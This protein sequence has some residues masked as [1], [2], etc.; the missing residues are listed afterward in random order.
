VYFLASKFNHWFKRIH[1]LVFGGQLFLG[2]DFTTIYCS[3]SF[4][5]PFLSSFCLQTLTLNSTRESDQAVVVITIRVVGELGPTDPL[6]VQ[7]YNIILRKWMGTLNMEEINRIFYDPTRAIELPDYK[8]V[9]W[10]GVKTSLRQ[11]ENSL[12]LNVDITHKV[13]RTDSVLDNIRE[14]EA[15]ARGGNKRVCKMILQKIFLQ[16]T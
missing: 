6:R 1:K 10:P 8:L 9:L 4:G 3:F 13:L 12:L 14:I 16:K 2:Y 5:L 7:Y 15:R 11:H